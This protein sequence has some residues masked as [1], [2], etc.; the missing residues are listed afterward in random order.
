MT[1]RARRGLAVVG[2]ALAAAL[3]MAGCS[4]HPGVAATVGDRTISQ[5]ELASTQ[6]ELATLLNDSSPAGVLAVLIE[7]PLFVDA[8]AE[9]G[10]GISADDA[11]ALLTQVSST[12]GLEE[13]EAWSQGSIDVAR[14]TLAVQGL[15]KVDGGADLL[16]ELKTKAA[17]LD[18][19]VNPQYGTWRDGT[20]A[21]LDQPW[22]ATPSAGDGAASAP[23]VP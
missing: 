6:R 17:D 23:A 21:P 1:V 13:P 9:H 5:D 22:I 2:V 10:I 4:A 16:T 7:T 15:Q 3:T 12:A 18:V 14:F 11:T 20:V 19:T 8:A